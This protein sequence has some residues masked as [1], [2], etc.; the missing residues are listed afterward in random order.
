MNLNTSNKRVWERLKSDPKWRAKAIKWLKRRK[1]VL[2]TRYKQKYY[3][4]SV[5]YPKELALL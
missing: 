2:K 5:E 1:R 4:K 3:E